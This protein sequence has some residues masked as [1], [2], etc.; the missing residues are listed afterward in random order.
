MWTFA[1]AALLMLIPTLGQATTWYVSNGT[2]GN[3]GVDANSCDTAKNINTPKRNI[4][5]T[6]GA[7]AC[8]QA[9]GDIIDVRGGTYIET[10]KAWVQPLASG[11]AGNPITLQGH[12]GETVWLQP[13]SGSCTGIDFGASNGK[14]YW[15]F[16][17]I[18]LDGR[19]MSCG[20]STVY[21]S[22][23]GINATGAIFQ[24]LEC[25]D[26]S[27]NGGGGGT[28][29]CIQ[30]AASNMLITNVHMHDTHQ[31]FG[32]HGGSYAIYATRGGIIIEKSIFHDTGGYGVQYND[33]AGPPGGWSGNIFRYN[34]VYNTGRRSGKG[35]GG[36]VLNGSQ[37]GAIVHSNV[38]YGV[39]KGGGIDMFGDTD[40]K[41]YN[42]TIVGSPLC[43]GVGS[44]QGSIRPVIKNNICKNNAGGITIY[45]GASGAIVDHNIIH[46]G[47]TILNSGTGG[48]V[49]AAIT[50]DPKLT[51]LSTHNYTLLAGSPAID[52]GV[53]LTATA[54]FDVTGVTP[55]TVPMEIGAYN[56]GTTVI[57]LHLAFLTPPTTVPEDTAFSVVV[58]ARDATNALSTTFTNVMTIAKAS[59]T[60]VLGGTLTCTASGGACTFANLTIDTPGTFTLV[61]SAPGADPVTSSPFA[62][63]DVTIPPP[64]AI[65]R[66]V[67]ILR[68]R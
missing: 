52:A 30:A 54:P 7:A 34:T 44:N 32:D 15:K 40:S 60:G 8:A 29:L 63:L 46:G 35:T 53:N 13:P 62:V 31:T 61:V 43:I 23:M 26:A 55:F 1:L 48:T 56:F 57:P 12:P 17:R 64:V 36:L 47:G 51:N 9:P 67:R 14:P 19:N 11:A 18:N 38:I 45:G 21:L 28:A 4:G 25:K 42:N 37:N 24:D 20:A 2:N 59:G 6:A 22:S 39:V 50:T 33:S 3:L 58:E 10:F 5:G 41:V 65:T 68:V 27:N 66:A 49:A 16:L